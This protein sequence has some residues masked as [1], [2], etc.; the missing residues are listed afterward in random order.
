MIEEVLRI[1]LL[2]TIPETATS[3]RETEK[4]T[5]KERGTMVETETEIAETSA[6]FLLLLLHEEVTSEEVISEEVLRQR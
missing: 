1:R 3:A 4:E 6:P 5:E 2:A